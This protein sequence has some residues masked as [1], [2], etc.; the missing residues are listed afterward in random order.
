VLVRLAD[1]ARSFDA[2]GGPVRVLFGVDL[3]VAEGDRVLITGP[4]GAGK[5]TLLSVLGLLDGGFTG[6]YTLLGKDVASASSSRLQTWR[7]CHVATAFQDLHL[8]PTLTAVENVMVPARAAGVASDAARTRA[9]A[10]LHAAGLQHRFAHRP[11]ALSGGERRRVALARALVNRPAVLLLDEPL[12]GL[13]AAS[14]RGVLALLQAERQHGAIIAAAH[15][16][17]QL[18]GA[19]REVALRAGRLHAVGA[20]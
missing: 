18:G 11:G 15:D 6:T 9:K 12:T 7:L 13:D 1:V 14:Q 5:T 2:D 3:E 4:S 10:L 8:V 16:G 20:P 19:W 17:Q